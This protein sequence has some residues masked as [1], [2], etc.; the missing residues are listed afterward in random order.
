[1]TMVKSLDTP[2]VAG[3][4]QVALVVNYSNDDGSHHRF[5]TV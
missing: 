3:H 4:F 1:M 5:W 2:T